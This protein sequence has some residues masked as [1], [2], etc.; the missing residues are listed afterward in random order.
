VLVKRFPTR[1]ESPTQVMEPRDLGTSDSRS[2]VLLQAS[3]GV[4]YDRGSF[5]GRGRHLT[6]V[7]S[8]RT[9]DV[10]RQGQE[11]GQAWTRPVKLSSW[12]LV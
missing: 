11:D 7:I 5:A 8:I 9:S 6:A 2:Q 3:P 4:C 10:G 12:T 1:Q